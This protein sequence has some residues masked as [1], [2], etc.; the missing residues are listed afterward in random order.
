VLTPGGAQGIEYGR[1]IDDLLEDGAAD[2][3]QPAAEAINIPTMLSAI[4]PT[5][6]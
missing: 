2:W 4:P 3:R 1:Q 5:A 6:L